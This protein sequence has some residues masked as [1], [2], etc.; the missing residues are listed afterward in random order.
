MKHKLDLETWNRKDHFNLFN[1][2]DE[3]YL[4]VTVQIDCTS[5][6]HYAKNNGVSFFLCQLYFSLR[7]AQIVEPFKYRIE[8]EDVFVYDQINAGSTIGRRNGTFGFVHIKYNPEFS[9]F[10]IEANNEVERVQKRT[11]LERPTGDN[12]IRYSSLPWIDFTSLSHARNLSVKDSCPR[13][14]FGKMTENDGKRI[15][16]VSIH[17]HHAL[18]DGLHVG[19]YIEC[20]QELMNTCG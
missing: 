18:I 2:F 19:Q 13:I 8:G 16:P 10:I 17:V 11:D 1:Q 4:G 7:S 9:K 5:A 20:F 3:P 15:M 14:S 12:L 6:Y